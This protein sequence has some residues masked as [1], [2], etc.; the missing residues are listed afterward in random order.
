MHI[1]YSI[2]I[3]T[4]NPEERLL[5]RCLESIYCLK[6]IGLDVEILLID[7]NST[8]P[9]VTVPY[10][11]EYVNKMTNLRVIVEVAQGLTFARMA[12]IHHA[13][14][15]YVVFFDDDNEPVEDYLQQLAVLH[16]SKKQVAVWGPGN[17]YVDFVDGIDKDIEDYLRPVFQERHEPAITFSNLCTWQECYP[18][19]T[20]MSVD[21]SYL[22]EYVE[23][24]KNGQFT[25]TGR[26]GT[27]LS[28]GE[29]VQIVLFCIAKGRSA[30]VAPELKINHIIP[31][32]RTNPSYI[33]RLIYGAC[34]GGSIHTLEVLP[35]HEVVLSSIILKA[36]RFSR[37]AIKGYLKLYFNRSPAVMFEFVRYIAF[38]SGVYLA[39]GKS[40]PLS[41][42]W[43]IKKLKLD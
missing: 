27:S 17:V 4:Y 19:G 38:N 3:C 6:T 31:G 16:E 10:I 24:V 37:R 2:I 5:K 20:G 32:K 30:G 28:S 21:T 12:G 14:G 36:S 7:N 39:L 22:K 11:K 34:I 25:S 8:Q 29:D 35:Q 40:I 42:Q 15:D 9:L 1:N 18:Y 13:K 43:V 26:N 33:R 41:V 23:V